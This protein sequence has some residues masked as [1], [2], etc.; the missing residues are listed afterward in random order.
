MT[1]RTEYLEGANKINYRI[2]E[3]L[4]SWIK[5]ES[6]N[7]HDF[8]NNPYEHVNYNPYILIDF[9]KLTDRL[10]M[11]EV[12]ANDL[13]IITEYKKGNPDYSVTSMY[14]S[15]LDEIDV[16]VFIR[17]Q[18]WLVKR[19]NDMKTMIN[20][21]GNLHDLT[22]LSEYVGLVTFDQTKFTQE[23]TMYAYAIEGT[24]TVIQYKLENGAT[25]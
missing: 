2:T 24:N 3:T 8:I 22:P 19:Y 21:G 14:E 6:S 9:S 23:Y 1:T 7:I 11:L 16:Q 25:V 13:M 15:A 10:N 5:N 4:H 12:I 20:S 17:L 18:D